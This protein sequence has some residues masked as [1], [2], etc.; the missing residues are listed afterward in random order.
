MTEQP[1]APAPAPEQ[2]QQQQHSAYPPPV[3][4]EGMPP[5]GAYMMLGPPGVVYM[6]P[7]PPQGQAFQTPSASATASQPAMSRPKRKQVKMAC[8][9]CAAA[10]K[11]CD[12]ARPCERCQKYGIAGLRK[13]KAG[14]AD[15]QSYSAG[16]P[17]ALPPRPPAPPRLLPLAP[18]PHATPTRGVP[19]PHLLPAPLHDAPA[20]L[21]ITFLH[22]R[23]RSA[24]RKSTARLPTRTHINTNTLT[25]IL[26]SSTPNTHTRT[27]G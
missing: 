8:T 9:N 11:R 22:P 19:L 16:P 12:E 23:R 25:S 17:P 5:P 24:G 13:N 6:H 14:G 3:L 1:K 10:C 4:Q 2:Q 7:P 20:R 15:G 27:P 26:T 18:R 21:P